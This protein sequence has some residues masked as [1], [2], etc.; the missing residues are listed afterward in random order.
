MI[1]TITIAGQSIQLVALPTHPGLAQVE[2]QMTDAVAIDSSPF[3]GQTQAQ[4]WL[5][6]DMWSGTMTLP[7]LRQCDKQNWAA[8]LAQLRGMAYA[9]QLSDPLYTGPQGTPLVATGTTPLIPATVTNVAGDQALF[10][11]NWKASTANLL[12]RGDYLQVGY[13]LHIVLDP[14]TS[15]GSGN[16]T[17]PIWPS[18]REAPTAGAA[19]ILNKP[20]GLFRRAKN[21]QGWSVDQSRLSRMSFPVVEYR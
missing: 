19:I 17:I 20:A 9:M 11:A 8:A 21:Q 7:P 6:A 12:K 1:S 4:Q 5:G 15:D 3:T 14:V 13:R 18:L 10:T 2:F 16:A